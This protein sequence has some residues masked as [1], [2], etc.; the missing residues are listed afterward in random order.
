M[1]I[2]NLITIDGPSASGKSSV[3]RLVA[4]HLGWPWVSTG[5]FYRGLALAALKKDIDS[6]D[7]KSLVALAHSQ[8]WEVK[9]SEN[10]EVFI[11]EKLSTA[12]IAG[13]EVG[14]LARRTR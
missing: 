7:E 6:K 4:S 5:A 10:T 3:S 2:H 14:A 12:E 1:S 11:D 8:N 13:E 9:M